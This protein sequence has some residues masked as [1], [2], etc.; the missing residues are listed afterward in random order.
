MKRRQK[1]MADG[2]IFHHCRLGP[3]AMYGGHERTA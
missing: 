1:C 3:H 2:S